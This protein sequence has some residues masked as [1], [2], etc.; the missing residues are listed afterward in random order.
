MGDALRSWTNPRGEDV[1]NA[2]VDVAIFAAALDGYASEG[3]AL[4]SDGEK[5]ALV[6]GVHTICAELSA[7]FLA[8]ALNESYFGFDEKRFATR[9]DHNLLRARGQ[10]ALAQDVAR[11]RTDLNAIVARAFG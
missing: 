7:R 5:T 3:R 11:R 6:D 4:V 10:W 8:D 2:G 9:G 1:D